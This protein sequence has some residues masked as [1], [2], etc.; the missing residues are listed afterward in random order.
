[1]LC[2]GKKIV[3]KKYG[4]CNATNVLKNTITLYI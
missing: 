4:E 1:M 2:E 3:E